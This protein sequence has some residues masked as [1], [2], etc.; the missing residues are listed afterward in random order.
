MTEE[1]LLKSVM[2]MS[3]KENEENIIKE[4]KN[5]TNI[6][7]NFNLNDF[8]PSIQYILEM[9]FTFDDAVLAMSVVGDNPELMLQY[10]YSQNQI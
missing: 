8:S 9:G 2:E 10:I 7:E 6:N 4:E 3:K 5:I 1:E